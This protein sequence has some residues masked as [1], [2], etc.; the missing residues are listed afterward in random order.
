MKNMDIR[1]GSRSSHKAPSV[2][3]GGRTLAAVRD[4]A[5]DPNVATTCALSWMT[6]AWGGSPLN[7]LKAKPVPK[8]SSSA[9]RAPP[10]CHGAR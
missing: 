7:A 5:E 8:W 3:T 10:A 1:K 2:I 9:T 4:A 6:R